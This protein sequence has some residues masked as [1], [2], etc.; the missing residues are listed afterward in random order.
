MTSRAR[1]GFTLIELLVV[2][3]IIAVLIALLLPAVQAAREAARR[4]QCVNNLKQIG[5]ALHNYHST[6]NKF[7]LGM[8][9]APFG[10]PTDFR[11]WNGFSPHAQMLGQLEQTAAYNAINFAWGTEGGPLAT[12]VGVGRTIN[13]TVYNMDIRVFLCP[14]DPNVDENHSCSYHYSRGATTQVNVDDTTGMF[15]RWTC[16]GLQDCPDGSSNTIAFAESLVGQTGVGN[17]YRGNMISGVAD[18]TPS[19]A[20]YNIATNPAVLDQA[21]AICLAGFRTSTT[22]SS[23]QVREE[24]GQHWIEGRYDFTSFNTAATPNPVAF[25]LAG[26]RLAPGNNQADSQQITP[27]TSNHPGGV[28]V[29]MS[30]GSSR[31]IKDSINRATWWALGT[32]AWGEVISADSF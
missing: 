12:G 1:G 16:Y 25:P 18:T 27:A 32:K 8:G 3:A 6:H 7:P 14:S 9:K 31:F 4:S 23:P 22:S 17:R 29:L 21:M 5:I 15:A 20:M 26:C 28:N 19:V 13:L 30:D 2:I 10:N 11:S 24:R